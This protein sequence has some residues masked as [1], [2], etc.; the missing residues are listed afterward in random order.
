MEKL[1]ETHTYNNFITMNPA[2]R[3]RG[4][5]QPAW[6]HQQQ[7]QHQHQHQRQQQQQH[8]QQQQQPR[9][10]GKPIPA[11][12]MSQKPQAPSTSF[13][14][15]STPSSTAVSSRH[16]VPLRSYERER[17]RGRGRGKPL[18]AWMTESQKIIPSF[19]AEAATNQLGTNGFVSSQESNRSM[20]ATSPVAPVAPAAPGVSWKCEE[21]GWKNRGINAVCGGGSSS[22]GCGK[23]YPSIPVPVPVVQV[24]V[25]GNSNTYTTSNYSSATRGDVAHQAVTQHAH[26]QQQQMNHPKQQQTTNLS[27]RAP[28]PLPPPQSYGAPSLPPSLPPPSL[29]S[30][31]PQ[32]APHI[33][34]S[35]TTIHQQIPAAPT[36]IPTSIP[37]PTP[38]PTPTTTPT[39]H[40]H[41]TRHYDGNSQKYYLFNKF[42]GKTMWEP[43][44]KVISPIPRQIYHP[45]N[46]ISPP[47]PPPPPPPP[48]LPAQ[49]QPVSRKRAAPAPAMMES[50]TQRSKLSSTT[51]TASSIAIAAANTTTTINNNVSIPEPLLKLVVDLDHT[52]FHTTQDFHLAQH[53]GF[54]RS[55]EIKQFSLPDKSFMGKPPQIHYIKFR[56]GLHEFLARCAM[57][58]KLYINTHATTEYARAVVHLI[59]PHGTYFG[60]RMMSRTTEMPMLKALN[61]LSDPINFSRL[62]YYSSIIV[63]DRLDVWTEDELESIVKIEPY[64]Y[65]CPLHQQSSSTSEI[66]AELSSVDMDDQLMHVGDVLMKVE[67]LY[68]Q[69]YNLKQTKIDCREFLRHFRKGVLTNVSI[70]FDDTLGLQTRQ[71]QK[72]VQY[73]GANVSKEVLRGAT[74]HLITNTRESEKYQRALRSDIRIVSLEWMTKSMALFKHMSEHEYPINFKQHEPPEI[75]PNHTRYKD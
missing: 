19:Q 6:M 67:S 41:I 13:S 14:S 53:M 25:P 74:S 29:P 8:H 66:D 56:P 46:P 40:S 60:G 5:I 3:G 12:M 7:Q 63:D 31:L 55:P 54:G 51:M 43:P 36:L 4:R 59:D 69:F 33:V 17:G 58:Y 30:H 10:R 20:L 52:L 49:Q 21:C 73:F 18:P 37:I 23:P 34:M 22:H 11:W 26:H 38:I 32:P 9:G 50:A 48:L 65:F 42:T 16:S 24:A 72:Y 28:L 45:P 62:D 68:K 47:P 1:R 15:S 39:N 44:K 70:C 27:Y 2:G 35:T 75:E 71:L 57:S 64:N 61:Q